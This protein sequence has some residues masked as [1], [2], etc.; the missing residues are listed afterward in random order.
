MQYLNLGCGSRCHPDWINIDI[1]S[2]APGVTAHDIC[3]GI[4]FPDASFDVVYH[5]NLLEHIRRDDAQFLMHECYRVM[6]AGG[7][8]RVAVP[9]LE[10]IGRLLL[11]I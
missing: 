1:K 11:N 5:S 7:I 2:G 9:D 10:Q 8:L 3:H 6:K 4:P